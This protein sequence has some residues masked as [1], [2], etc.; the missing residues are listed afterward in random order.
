[1]SCRTE[2]CRMVPRCDGGTVCMKCCVEEK[3]SHCKEQDCSSMLIDA[4]TSICRSCNPHS[5]PIAGF[6]RTRGCINKSGPCPGSLCRRCCLKAGDT[7]CDRLLC[8]LCCQSIRKHTHC[9]PNGGCFV[10]ICSHSLEKRMYKIIAEKE[11]IAEVEKHLRE[12]ILCRHRTIYRQYVRSL[13]EIDSDDD[14][15]VTLRNVKAGQTFTFK[16]WPPPSFGYDSDL[17]ECE[18]VIEDNW[19]IVYYFHVT[20]KVD[21]DKITFEKAYI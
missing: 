15:R 20:F 4:E 19:D 18:H 12:E 1:M 16:D 9:I 3:H 6:C 2:N 7:P 10:K 17:Y 11:S 13:G 21:V 8:K 14:E 5:H